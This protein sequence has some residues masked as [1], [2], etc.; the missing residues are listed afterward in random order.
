MSSYDAWIMSLGTEVVQGRVLNTN[1][2]YLGRRLTLLGFR[3]V[4]ILSLIDDV[5]IIA[6]YITVVLRDRPRVI[7]TTGGLGPTYDDRTLEAVAKALNRKLALSYDALNM[8]K[9]KYEARNMPLT[10]ERIKM[11]YLP[12]GSIAIPNPVGT[13]PGCWIEVENAIMISLP[14]VPQE[15]EAMWES[16]VEPRLRL[17]GPSVYIAE[18]LMKIVG[19][20]ESSL[21]PIVKGVL[22]EAPAE[23]YIKSHPKGEELGKPVIELYI[24]CSSREKEKAMTTAENTAS[25]IMS[26]IKTEFKASVEV[27]TRGVV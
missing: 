26:I 23:L 8:V 12:D 6:R 21:A 3:V 14:G 15:M 11:A 4:G 20:P 9:R 18:I 24:M 2:S 7:V 19:V 13:A 16:W 27:L 1:A 25:K 5:D 22:R 10:E 17:I